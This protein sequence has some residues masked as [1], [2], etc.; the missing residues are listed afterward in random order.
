MSA[1][2]GAP[3]EPRASCEH[4]V[5]AY[6]DEDFLAAVVTRY[7]AAGL[8]RHE[9]AIVIATA[10]HER[11]FTHQL[12]VA[13]VDVPDAVG[14]GRLVF[15]D[16]ERALEA[17]MRGGVP[18]RTTF[19]AV[20]EA[21]LARVRAAGYRRVRVYGEIVDF[22]WDGD[23]DAA[24]RLEALWNETLSDPGL[25]LLCAYRLNPLDR[26]VQDVLRRVAHCHSEMLAPQDDAGFA[27]AVDRAYAEVFGPGRETD[28][29]RG[30]MAAR[31]PPAPVLPHAQ[32][33]IFGLRDLSARLAEDVRRRAH[34]YYR[35]RQRG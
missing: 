5:Q 19:T 26:H 29:L 30:L 8:A 25:S 4:L 11:G 32:A 33:A 22:L 34:G 23:L 10:A 14:H 17:I 12:A 28:A 13:G 2:P 15:V 31:V 27:A 7:L 35:E 9:A 24:L 20:V 16:A 1:F 6:T 18:D 3:L 21:A